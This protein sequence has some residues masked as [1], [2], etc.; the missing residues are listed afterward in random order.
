MTSET[1]KT[2]VFVASLPFSHYTY[3][4][5]VW[6]QRKKDLIKGCENVMY[7]FERVPAAIVPDNLKAAVTRS[8]RNEPAINEDFIAFTEHYFT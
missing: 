2:E 8:D 7:Y 3:C 4:E 5:A 1:K 6:S